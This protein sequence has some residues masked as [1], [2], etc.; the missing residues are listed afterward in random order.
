MQI[1]VLGL[2][3]MGL[4]I[5][6]HLATEHEVLRNDPALGLHDDLS[7]VD[8]LVTV[9]PGPSAFASAEPLLH[10]LRPEAIWLDLSSN[11]PRVASRLAASIRAQSVAAPMSGGPSAALDHTLHF[12]V[13]GPD[14]TVGPLLKLL[15]SYEVIGA[16]VADAHVAKLL[17]NLLWFGQAVAAAE[18]LALGGRL[19]VPP[20]ALGPALAAG[21]GGGRFL[22][23]TVDALLADGDILDFGIDRVVEQLEILQQLAVETGAPFEVSAAVVQTYRDAQAHFGDGGELLAARY[24]RSR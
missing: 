18:A 9:L 19:G 5:A 14:E 24:I 13:G 10:A 22:D 4:P 16:S 8:V 12:T 15:G 17:S 1:G 20:E 2:G 21:A 23:E 11:D 3:R 6:G 7:G